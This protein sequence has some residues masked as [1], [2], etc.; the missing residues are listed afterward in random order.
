MNNHVDMSD[1]ELSSSTAPLIEQEEV[2]EGKEEAQVEEIELLD[3]SKQL[4]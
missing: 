2:P 4:R 1:A 3:M